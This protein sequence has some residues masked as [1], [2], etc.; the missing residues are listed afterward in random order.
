MIYWGTIRVELPHELPMTDEQ[1]QTLKSK[2]K[3]FVQETGESIG[4]PAFGCHINVVSDGTLWT[5]PPKE[6]FGA[7]G[8][9]EDIVGKTVVYEVMKNGFGLEAGIQYRMKV[10]ACKVHRAYA[11]ELQGEVQ[12]VGDVWLGKLYRQLPTPVGG[13]PANGDI[14]AHPWCVWV[15][16]PEHQYY[17]NSVDI[18]IIEIF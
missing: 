8:M 3:K 17:D 10:D 15:K 14:D 16:L 11:V 12:Q 5:N 1:L 4:Y 9:P 18:K 13:F 2:L 7:V 6:V